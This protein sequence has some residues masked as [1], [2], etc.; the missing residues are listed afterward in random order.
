M[1]IH[2]LTLV[3]K[4]D[5]NEIN[6]TTNRNAL[7]KLCT[8]FEKLLTK[9]AEKDSNKIIVNVP[10]CY[11]SYDIITSTKSNLGQWKYVLELIKCYDFFGL[12][13]DQS[14]LF[15][16]E[17]PPEGF[18]ELLHVIELMDFNDDIVKFIA[19]NIPADYDLSE[20]SID[21]LNEIVRA[22]TTYKIIS[23]SS[24]KSIKI[25][26]GESGDLIHTIDDNIKIQSITCNNKFIIVG[27]RHHINIRDVQTGIIIN[28]LDYPNYFL[29]NKNICITPDN[30]LILCTCKNDIEILDK[31]FSI[32]N[33]F[34]RHTE[35]ILSVCISNDGT[36][37]VSGSIDKTIKIWDVKTGSLIR[38]LKGH[39][40]TIQCVCISPDNNQIASG[41]RDN[42]V[43]IWDFHTGRT[44]YTLYE[45]GPEY[46]LHGSGP[47][48]FG[49]VNTVCYSS[50]NN[51]IASGSDCV[52]IWDAKTGSLINILDQHTKSVWSL[53]FSCDNSK[54]ISGSLDHTIKIW[55][56]Y[57]GDL[58]RTLEGHTNEILGVYYLRNRDSKLVKR[59][60]KFIGNK[61]V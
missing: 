57:T 55:D 8:Y 30:K 42:Y 49:W 26:N 52:K 59:I 29:A 58:I 47:K 46:T 53:C 25:W 31:N 22:E 9:F 45:P 35:T 4:D 38:T 40:Q 32:V 23:A 2:D 28:S 15:N 7:C 12:D 17:I 60:K 5:T 21:L 1:D 54:I 51:K 61:I 50:D 16:L 20:L 39:K 14:I 18:E 43:K 37:L 13:F 24:D 27:D 33:R 6:V 34:S 3:L 44:I 41:S 19:K 10:N 48:K 36:I 56:V 11:V